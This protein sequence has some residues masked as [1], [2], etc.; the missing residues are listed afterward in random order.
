MAADGSVIIS[1]DAD[2]KLAIKEI[3]NTSEK[4]GELGEKSEK[5]NKDLTKLAAGAAAVSVAMI[6]IGKEVAEASAK[7]ESAFARTQTIMDETEMSVNEMRSS[8][9]KL[10]Q[11]SAMAATDVSEAVYQAISGSVATQDA[12]TFVE[13]SNKL[14]VAGFTDLTSA[15]D[16]LT[17]TLNS[18]KLEASDVGGISNVLIQTQNLGKTSVNELSASMGRAISTGSAYGVNL[19]NIATTYVELTRSG[20]ATSEATTFPVCSTSWAIPAARSARYC[21]RRPAGASDSSCKTAGPSVMC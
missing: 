20:I 5:T 6:A 17:T 10:S 19:Q 11:D 4:I 14:A 12:V 7:F 2:G 9:L 8:I 16:V 21:S 1:I 18:Y 13:Q 3:D 15:T